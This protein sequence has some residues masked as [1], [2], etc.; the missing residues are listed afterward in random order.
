MRRRPLRGERP[1]AA[2]FISGYRSPRATSLD[3]WEQGWHY[4]RSMDYSQLH[5]AVDQLSPD[6]ARALLVVVTSML[7]RSAEAGSAGV[8]SAVSEPTRHRLSFT[9]AGS[10]PA[11][12]AEHADAYLRAGE[13]GHPGS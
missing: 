3:V 12:L 5:R 10:G 6:Q 4:P 7:G 11:D 2:T 9:A 8:A 1:A 13:F